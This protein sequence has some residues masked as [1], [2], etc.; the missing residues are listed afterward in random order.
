MGICT[1]YFV[2]SVALNESRLGAVYGKRDNIWTPRVITPWKLPTHS[3][4][5][6]AAPKG[7]RARAADSWSRSARV[8]GPP[9]P[10]WESDTRQSSC[11]T[12]G[13]ARPPAHPCW[14]GSSA[15]RRT[16]R[17]PT[18]ATLCPWSGTTAIPGRGHGSPTRT[19]C[20][21]RT[22]RRQR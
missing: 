1:I 8:S 19:Q 7:A 11:S 6:A 12:T 2:G 15:T 21:C 22:K 14:T 13:R 17:A 20:C 9:V 10:V 18:A 16:A 5:P 4:G 3:L